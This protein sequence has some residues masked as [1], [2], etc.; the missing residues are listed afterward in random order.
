MGIKKKHATEC[1]V[2]VVCN[3]KCDLAVCTLHSRLFGLQS[4]IS[5][6]YT[7]AMRPAMPA[8]LPRSAS[9]CF[10]KFNGAFS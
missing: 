6:P 7:I 10:T 5:I 8:D 1:Q 9:E 4:S 2:Q 3:G